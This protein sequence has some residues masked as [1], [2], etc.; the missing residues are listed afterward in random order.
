MGEKIPSKLPLAAVS[1]LLT[2]LVIYFWSGGETSP[3]VQQKTAQT[4]PVVSDEISNWKT[5]QSKEYGFE[6]KHPKEWSVPQMIV[7]RHTGGGSYPDEESVWRLYIGQKTS[8]ACE[9][10]DCYELYFDAYGAKSITDIRKNLQEDQL[11]RL[12]SEYE[13][14]GGSILVYEEGGICG[15][16][17][18]LIL[19]RTQMLKF[20]SHCG[21]DDA[22]LSKTF[23][24]ILATFKLTR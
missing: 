3:V 16:K 23:D 4:V 10:E 22:E 8:G 2:G 17:K 1:L 20:T 18:A 24:Q 9:G 11:I 5:Y 13:I 14:S 21:A 15:S 6:F 12:T 19:E 7:G